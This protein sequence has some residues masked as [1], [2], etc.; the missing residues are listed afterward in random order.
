MTVRNL[1]YLLKP[2]S[3]ALVGASSRPGD[4]GLITARSLKSGGFSGPVWLVNPKYGSIDG[5]DCY[6]SVAGLPAPP[7]LGIVATPPETVPKL[8]AELGTKG[9]RAVVVDLG[10]AINV[11]PSDLSIRLVRLRLS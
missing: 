9:A 7:D 5:Q 3:I 2:R 8:I 6:P 10:F 11:E 1:D 4:V